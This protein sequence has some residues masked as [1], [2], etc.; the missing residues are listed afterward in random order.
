MWQR[1]TSCLCVTWL[2]HMWYDSFMTRL[3]VTWLNHVC[4]MTYSCDKT[5]SYVTR[6]IHVCAQ[7]VWRCYY[8]CVTLDFI[9]THSYVKWFIHLWRDCFKRDLTHS[10]VTWLMHVRTHE[11]FLRSAVCL[12]VIGLIYASHDSSTR[13]VTHYVW[14]MTYSRCDTTHSHV[15]WLIYMHVQTV[16]QHSAACLYDMTHVYVTTHSY[17]SWLVFDSLIWHHSPTCVAWLFVWRG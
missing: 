10:C 16:W 5:H 1:A 14:N 7:A 6:L 4:G 9:M 13:A 11:V 17:I 8:A 15:T 3:K 2:L 12:C